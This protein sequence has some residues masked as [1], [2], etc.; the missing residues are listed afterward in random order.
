MTK[1]YIVYTHSGTTKQ[2]SNL[3]SHLKNL[4]NI[5]A[6]EVL[7]NSIDKDGTWEG[8]DLALYKELSKKINIP[9]VACGGA[10]N[11]ESIER[12]FNE[13]ECNA[14]GVGS[15]VLFQKKDYGVLV[16]YPEAK[17][18]DALVSKK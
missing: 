4:E 6:G 7:L 17:L 13:T 16:N 18:I 12:L 9:L 1:K 15:M 5:G 10:K 2:K 3:V 14:A 8:Y 11:M